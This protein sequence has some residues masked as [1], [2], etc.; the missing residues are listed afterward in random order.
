M[1]PVWLFVDFVRSI[2]DPF[3]IDPWGSGL[4]TRQMVEESNLI[5]EPWSPD[6]RN[7][8]WSV[9][10]Q[11]GRI[12][13]FVENGWKDPIQIDVGVPVLGYCV[14]QVLDGHHRL[15]AAIHKGD[16]AILCFVDGQVDVIEP[17]IVKISAH[18]FPN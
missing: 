6:D 15:G 17:H 14:Q 10:Q 1:K 11:A 16:N 18:N 2:A 12:G 4:V 3:E 9:E 5:A 7:Q 8:L 13:W